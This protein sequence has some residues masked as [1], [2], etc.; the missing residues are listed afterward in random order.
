MLMNGSGESQL[1]EACG[2]EQ[3]RQLLEPDREQL[4]SSS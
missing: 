3:Q 2:L 1:Q 4:W